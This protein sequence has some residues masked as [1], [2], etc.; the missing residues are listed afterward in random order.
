MRRYSED[1]KVRIL[2]RALTRLERIF[3]ISPTEAWAIGDEL[4]EECVWASPYLEYVFGHASEMRILLAT[5]LGT[6]NDPNATAEDIAKA[7]AEY[8]VYLEKNFRHACGRDQH[9]PTR[10][11]ETPARRVAKAA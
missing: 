3:E 1:E 4:I 9:F 10:G 2:D 11:K 5:G 6:I 7:K 8:S